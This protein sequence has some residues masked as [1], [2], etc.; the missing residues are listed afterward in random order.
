M[1]KAKV[2]LVSPNLK[3]MADGVNRI[4][5][6]LGLMLIAQVLIENGHEVKIIDTA[7]NGWQNREFVDLQK[8]KVMIGQSDKDI[9]NLIDDFSPD[10]LGISDLFSNIL[11]SA[12]QIARLAKKV[13]KNINVILG[14]NHIS[15]AVSDYKYSLFNNSKLSLTE[16]GTAKINFTTMQTNIPGVFAAGDI[17][18]GAS[19]VVWAIRDGRDAATQIEKYLNSILA[20]K[21]VAA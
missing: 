1:K 7:L 12:H 13:N 21:G 14:G 3:G 20:N 6:S 17:V 2:L 11:G 16:W 4:Q 8:N 10:V 19:L 18:R 15:N 5:P 9:M